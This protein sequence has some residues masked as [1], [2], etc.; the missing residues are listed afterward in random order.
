MHMVL[1]EVPKQGSA[2]MLAPTPGGQR[3]SQDPGDAS[4]WAF[5]GFS[6]HAE[7]THACSRTHL[8]VPFVLGP[9]NTPADVNLVRF[10]PA[11]LSSVALT[12]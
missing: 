10:T 5:K 9:Q 12:E 7:C 2:G 8:A 1:S 4:P 6:H 3:V 11:R